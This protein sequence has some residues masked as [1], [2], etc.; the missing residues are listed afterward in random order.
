MDV[1]LKNKNSCFNVISPSRGMLSSFPNRVKNGVDFLNKQNLSVEFS[2]N[3]FKEMAYISATPEER[4]QDIQNA[5]LNHNTNIIMASIGGYNSNQ[6]LHD[7]DYNIIRENPKVFC[8]YS[9]I[10][11]LLLGIYS[12]T[13]LVVFHGPCYLTELCEYPRPFEYTW[14]NFVDAMSGKAIDWNCPE[15]ITSEFYDWNIQENVMYE[16]KLTPSTPW[17]CIKKGYAE[18]KLIGGNLS[19]ILN[20]LGTE[21]LPTSQF[22]QSILF[23]EEPNCSLA[24]F[25]SLLYALKAHEVLKHI[26]GLVIGRFNNDNTDT[27][28]RTLY[29]ILIE[30]SQGY[31]FPIAT[32]IDLGHTDPMI[33]IPIGR[34]GYL[35]CSFDN[36]I[37]FGVRSAE[38]L[39]DN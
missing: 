37:K 12:K 23:I 18:G 15:S 11:A 2:K 33:T 39:Y 32:D 36:G 28:D 35:S 17:K 19:T 34:Q 5:F 21:F 31:D 3:S 10:T 38:V 26:K 8:G 27:Q 7:L 24:R 20:I 14:K 25:D 30:V 9:D 29:E 16:R 22:D 4:I 1:S 13:G 6:L